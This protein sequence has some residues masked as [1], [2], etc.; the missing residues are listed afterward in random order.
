MPYQIIYTSA[1]TTPMQM[2]DLEDILESAR[3]S[4]AE[5]GI[6]G[7]LVYVDGFFLQIL[8]GDVEA[9]LDLMGRISKDVRHET[10][11]VLR[12]GEI[13]TAVFSDWKMAYVSATAEEV[14]RWAGLSGTTAVPDIL[15]DIH[16]DEMKA[17]LVAKQILRVLAMEPN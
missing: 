15:A 12:Q 7:A 3:E 5:V 9:L 2:D 17:T 6:S 1:A 16:R 8:E 4:N 14:A 11:T 13:S 10:V